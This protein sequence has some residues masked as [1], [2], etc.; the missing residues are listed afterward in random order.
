MTSKQKNLIFILL[1][2]ALV[3]FYVFSGG[4]MGISLDFGEDALILSASDH[5]WT[6]PYDQIEAL[7]L[8]DLPETGTLLNGAEKRNL[9]FGTWE[10]DIWGEYTLCIDPR[11]RRCIVITAADDSHYVLNY[12]SAEA[13]EELMKLITD[14]VHSKEN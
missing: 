6:I 11:I 3:L 1:I 9:C 8:A 4:S 7:E 13:T 10:N 14:I 12:E 2:P 5:D